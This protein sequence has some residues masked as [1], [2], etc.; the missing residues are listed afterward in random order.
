ML[1][2][3]RTLDQQLQR[4]ELS[5]QTQA[6]RL[7]FALTAG[8]TLQLDGEALDGEG[9]R[10]LLA[11]ATLELADGSRLRIEPGGKD[12]GN[13]QRQLARLGDEQRSLLSALGVPSLAAAETRAA[14]AGAA[15]ERLRG[16]QTALQ[17]LAPK[18]V[19]ELQAQQQRRRARCDALRQQ[20]TDSAV[21]TAA[22]AQAALPTLAGAEAAL[23][24][25]EDA[26][27]SAEHAAQQR[28]NEVLLAQQALSNATQE[29]ERLDAMLQA[30]DRQQREQAAL[31][32]LGELRTRTAGLEHQL[33]QRNARISAAQPALLEQDIER[34]ERSADAA[35][36]S[37]RARRLELERLQASLSALDADGLEERAAELDAELERSARREAELSRRAQALELLRELLQRQRQALTRQLQAPL[38]RHLQHYLQLLFPGASLE[39]DEALVPQ[40]L[41]RPAQPQGAEQSEV[42]GLSYGAREQMGL[43]SRLAYADLLHEAGRPTLLM[44][45]DALVHSDA[46]RLHAMKRVL[47]DAAQRHQILLFSCHP[48]QWRDLGVEARELNALRAG[49]AHQDSDSVSTCS[50]K[51][52]GCPQR[53]S[54]NDRSV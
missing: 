29:L 53:A 41:L 13:L 32:Q 1:T 43:I 38:Q 44:L 42:D 18:G 26:L 27:Q 36:N 33:A 49:P 30:P 8:S 54:S 17:A 19:T 5:Q 20:L 46:E 12:T 25:A 22:D 45:D 7:H 6:T 39:V 51:S 40:L 15:A 37:A 16:H 2:E 10:L 9:E 31:V 52:T 48:Q 50:H 23:T 35:E 11:P 47:F 14:A 4:L 28:R 34:L 3:L 21:S 24:Q